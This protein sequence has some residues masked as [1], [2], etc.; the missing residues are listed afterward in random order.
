VHQFPWFFTLITSPPVAEVV[1]LGRRVVNFGQKGGF[2]LL[3]SSKAPRST[4]E[5][6]NQKIE[7]HR[8]G[9]ETQRKNKTPHLPYFLWHGPCDGIALPSGNKLQHFFSENAWSIGA[10]LSHKSY[11]QKLV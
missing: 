4:Q 8:G 7:V 10:F 5:Q 1:D 2:E 9:A 3:A 11:S 6:N